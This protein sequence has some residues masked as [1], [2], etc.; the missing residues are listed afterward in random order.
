M[1]NVCE[2]ISA[3]VREC[4]RKNVCIDWRRSDF[5]NMNCESPFEY[6][7]CGCPE[8]C[9]TVEA[10]N[11]LIASSSAAIQQDSKALAKISSSC[12]SNIN[13]GCFCP[14][15][16]VQKDN[17][18]MEARECKKCDQNH[19]LGD[20]WYTDKCTKCQCNSD[21]KSTCSTK[22][23]PMVICPVGWTK[24]EATGGDDCCKKYTCVNEPKECNTTLPVCAENQENKNFKNNDTEP[25][26]MN[27][28]GKHF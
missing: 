4:A 13:E 19:F 26:F 18:C 22:T 28:C 9:D 21:G 16:K 7:A 23:C 12:K 11:K 15:G 14:K 1:E 3:Y 10:K 20:E 17:L 27:V 5:C 6:S 8:T 24:V 2:P 25:C